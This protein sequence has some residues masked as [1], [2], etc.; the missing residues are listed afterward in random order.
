MEDAYGWRSSC[1]ERV[2]CCAVLCCLFLV[3]V[4][5][6]LSRAVLLVPWKGDSGCGV[7]RSVQHVNLQ[8][9][10]LRECV[11]VLSRG[12]LVYVSHVS[13]CVCVFFVCVR[14]FLYERDADVCRLDALPSSSSARSP[15]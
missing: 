4:L 15:A 13:F 10:G 3:V 11:R 9:R 5:S 12:R 6:V 1:T 8:R 2:L 7:R 14:V